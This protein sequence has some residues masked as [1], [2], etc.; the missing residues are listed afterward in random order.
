MCK[1]FF[2]KT[3]V[4]TKS[5]V[6]YTVDKKAVDGNKSFSS[7]DNRGRHTPHNKASDD[8]LASVRAHICSFP[9]M[10]PHCVRRNT[11]RTF[12]GSELNIL[13]MHQVVC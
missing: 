13:K 9:T 4:I 3:Y 7:P 5:L 6:W 8:M 12:L 2:L 11:S 1:K 10:E